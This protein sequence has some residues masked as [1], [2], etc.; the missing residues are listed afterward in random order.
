MQGRSE[1]VGSGATTDSAGNSSII[2]TACMAL[3]VVI[4][5][6]LEGLP[7]MQE[8]CTAVEWGSTSARSECQYT[9]L[10]TA[11]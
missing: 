8:E 9:V 10:L 3:G 5:I 11:V 2:E 1:R 4:C 6:V 7:A